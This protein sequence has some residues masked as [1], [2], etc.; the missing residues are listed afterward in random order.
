MINKL[1]KLSKGKKV[2]S[3]LAISMPLPIVFGVIA[4]A[5]NTIPQSDVKLGDTISVTA[6]YYEEDLSIQVPT[7]EQVIAR[8]EIAINDLIDNGAINYVEQVIGKYHDTGDNTGTGT[9]LSATKNSAN[10]S[11]KDKSVIN[12][13]VNEAVSFPSGYYSDEI[14]INNNIVNRG[15][16][17]ITVG[18]GET[19]TLEPGYYGET[20]ITANASALKAKSVTAV[21]SGTFAYSI[22]SSKH[23]GNTDT[24]T[25]T[26]TATFSLSAMGFKENDIVIVTGA[27]A[28]S[29]YSDYTDA[30]TY[31]AGASYTYT[32]EGDTLTIIATMK[33][34]DTKWYPDSVDEGHRGTSSKLSFTIYKVAMS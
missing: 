24:K 6:G 25:T 14:T 28:T 15:S 29:N 27:S 26:K 12:L 2:V 33:A 18:A 9:N 16:E 7:V 32:V 17:A 5:A 3:L 30:P 34:S 21:K 1:K 22:S 13:G 4:Y 8:G 11:I 19:I 20:T 10:I 23:E 31:P